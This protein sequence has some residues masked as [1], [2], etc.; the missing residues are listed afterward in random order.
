M[1]LLPPVSMVACLKL[2]NSYIL[3]NLGPAI[4]LWCTLNFCFLSH[5]G[6]DTA[7]DQGLEALVVPMRGHGEYWHSYS[8]E[9]PGASHIA[10]AT[11]DHDSK[12][13]QLEMALRMPN[14]TT[15]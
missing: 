8:S 7:S 10:K 14:G 13:S 6:I 9:K 12:R 3:W 1:L 2:C 11:S 15:I 5:V 4:E